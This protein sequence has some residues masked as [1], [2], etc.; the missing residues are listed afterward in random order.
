MPNKYTACLL[1]KNYLTP[2]LI[3]FEFVIK[4]L[5]KFEYLAG[6]YVSVKIDNVTRR[7]YSILNAPDNTNKFKL[8]I[9]TK[10]QGKG[11]LYLESLQINDEVEILAPLGHFV[12]QE[13]L[14][15]NTIFISTGSGI[16]PLN[17]MVDFLINNNLKTNIYFYFGTSYSNNLVFEDKYLNYLKAG[18]IID[19]KISLTRESIDANHIISARTDKFLD[20]L[21][22]DVIEHSVLYLCGGAAF[23][24]DLEIKALN[25]GIKKESIFYEKFYFS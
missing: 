17:S 7:S 3:E 20:L 25:I 24:D 2:R 10:P 12:I 6:Q 18:K 5:D 19:F 21:N 23:T 1:N 9:D 11:T 8:L 4:N 13:K 16:A 15:V 14:P 22:K